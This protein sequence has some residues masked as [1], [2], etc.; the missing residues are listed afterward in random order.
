MRIFAVDLSSGKISEKK[1]EKKLIEEFLGGRGLAIRLLYEENPPKVDPLSPENRL[2]IMTG[3]YTATA[4]SFTAF[5]NVTTKSPLTGT[6]SSAHSG[7][8]FSPQL[9]RAGVDGLIIKGKAK[10]PS[11][12]MIEDGKIEIKDAS[13]LWGRDVY[14]TTEALEKLHPGA[15]CIVI[16]PAGEKLV[17]YAAMMN[18]NWRAA[19]RGGVGAVMGSKNLKAIVA[20]GTGQVPQADENF[21]KESF[22]TASATVKEKAVA[23]STYGTPMVAG[24]TGKG[25]CIPTR[26]FSTSWFENYEKVTGDFMHKNGNFVKHMACF[27]CPLHCSKYN[28]AFGEGFETETEG[29]EYETIALFGPNVGNDNINGII[30]ANDL[31]NKYGI[32]TISAADSIAYAIE[33]YQKGYLSK[34]ETD[35]LELKWNDPATVVKLVEKIG[36]R[37][38]FGDFLAEGVKRMSERFDEKARSFAIHVKGMEPPGY[39]PRSLTGMA[40]AFA[41]SPRGACHLRGTVY[42]AELFQG[43]IDRKKLRGKTPTVVD[44]QDLATICDSMIICKFGARNAFGN[45]PENL[46]PL[47]KAA[48]GIDF[49]VKKL[50]EAAARIWTLER[51][52]NNREGFTKKD[53]ML[54]ERFYTEQIEDGPSKGQILDRNEFLAELEDYYA[55]RGW[56]K[57]GVPTKETL[58]KLNLADI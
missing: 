35:G 20:K 5:Y 55:A 58:K 50:K 29:P 34:K 30:K 32:D 16:G 56:D 42:V 38:G 12:L 47:M 45:N 10:K 37:E 43:I 2:I 11:Y 13:G 21:L 27:R 57:N 26:N 19:G 33:L 36:K 28:K 54:P 3:P 48:T 44:Y 22:K 8:H 23:F 31:C 49:D 17:R 14:E 1:I 6:C 53:D 9:R 7:G 51:M 41:T 46:A 39:E 24:I 40:L 52:Y 15:K 25:G 18:D 4:G